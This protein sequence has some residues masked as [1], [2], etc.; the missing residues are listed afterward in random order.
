MTIVDSTRIEDIELYD[1]L[2]AYYVDNINKLIDLFKKRGIFPLIIN[3]PSYR[4]LPSNID[5]YKILSERVSKKYYTEDL[6]YELMASSFR[7][8]SVVIEFQKLLMV[9]YL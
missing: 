5:E 4:K 2:N 8:Y 3:T 1:I 7:F 9:N 6:L